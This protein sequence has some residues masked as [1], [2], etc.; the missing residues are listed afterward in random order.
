[1]LINWW[2]EKQPVVYP[3]NRILF[4][5]KNWKNMNTCYDMDNPWKDY[6]K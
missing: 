3:Y 5:N 6:A 1:V 2:M 4:S